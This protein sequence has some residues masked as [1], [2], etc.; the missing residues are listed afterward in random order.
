MQMWAGF[1]TSQ[2][3][4]FEMEKS[5]EEGS[6]NSLFRCVCDEKLSCVV[7]IERLFLIILPGSIF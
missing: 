3:S 5:R 6:V 7:H 4:S 1:L 2:D